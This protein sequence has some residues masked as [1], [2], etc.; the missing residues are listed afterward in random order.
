LLDDG[1]KPKKNRPLF[2][3]SFMMT[4]VIC[5]ALTFVAIRMIFEQE[6]D[7]SPFVV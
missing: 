4:C 7:L 5:Y 1:P 3:A 6:P 2:A